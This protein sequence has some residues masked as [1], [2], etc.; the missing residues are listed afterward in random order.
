MRFVTA[1]SIEYRVD[2]LAHLVS[3]MHDDSY[4]HAATDTIFM[5]EMA[6]RVKFTTDQEIRSDS[7]ENFV[8]DLISI[9]YLKEVNDNDS[10][11]EDKDEDEGK[12]HGKDA[13]APRR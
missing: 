7:V 1:D 4:A 8:E 2:N 3:S 12:A 5:K 6:E 10:A 13:S 9:G 11:D